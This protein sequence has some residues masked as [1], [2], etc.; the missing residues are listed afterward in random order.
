[1]TDEEE[2]HHP[3][4][5]RAATDVAVVERSPMIE[6]SVT[7]WAAE[8]YVMTIRTVMSQADMSTPR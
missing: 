5:L 4:C 6:K 7:T 8:R 1:M 3:D 2:E